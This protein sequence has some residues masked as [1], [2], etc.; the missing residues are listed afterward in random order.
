MPPGLSTAAAPA[1]T[2]QVERRARPAASVTTTANPKRSSTSGRPTPVGGTEEPTDASPQSTAMAQT[3]RRS[4]PADRRSGGGGSALSAFGG[5]GPGHH[6]RPPAGRSVELE[7]RRRTRVLAS[8]IASVD[9][10]APAPTVAAR[11][12]S[13]PPTCPASCPGGGGGGGRVSSG[14]GGARS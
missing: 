11:S 9:V 6:G 1:S 13:L 3:N 5:V 4:S 14:G 7:R 12:A 8:P 10:A 2:I